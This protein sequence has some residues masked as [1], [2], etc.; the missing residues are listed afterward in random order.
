MEPIST[1]LVIKAAIAAITAALAI[2]AVAYVTWKAFYAFV[3]KAVNQKNLKSKLHKFDS[4]I[5]EIVA[6]AKRVYKENEWWIKIV[7]RAY[8]ENGNKAKLDEGLLSMDSAPYDVQE[9]LNNG[10]E[11][12]EVFAVEYTYT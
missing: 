2:A 1:A 9:T 5:E 10:Q 4:L 6:K 12:K 11:I 8:D 7:V 3:E